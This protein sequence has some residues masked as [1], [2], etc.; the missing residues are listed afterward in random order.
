MT[1]ALDAVGEA[2]LAWPPSATSGEMAHPER[3]GRSRP[4]AVQR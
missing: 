2:R 3:R 1:P 4:A